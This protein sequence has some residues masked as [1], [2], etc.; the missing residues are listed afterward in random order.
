MAPGNSDQKKRENKLVLPSDLK[1]D[2]T[3]SVEESTT[4]DHTSDVDE[5]LRDSVLAEKL[6]T[7]AI[8]VAENGDDRQSVPH[9]LRAAKQ[10]EHAQEWHLAALS[11]HAMADIFRSDGPE[12]NLERAIRFYRRA[13][14]AYESCGHFD[15]AAS[16]EYYVCDLRLWHAREFKLSRR[17]RIELFLYWATAGYGY[18]PLRVICSSVVMILA[19]GLIYWATGGIMDSDE[20]PVTDFSSAAY[21]S[22]STFLTINYGDLLPMSHVR[23]LTVVEGLF[24]L[25]MSSFFVVVLVNR[26]RH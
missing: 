16:L 15:E 21:F 6:Y 22:G 10:A 13:I 18:R 4:K 26:L 2:F 7:A 25:T 8:K 20:E 3:P 24:G 17:L 5:Y 14:A 23:W 1:A 9:L 11:L 12:K 19:F